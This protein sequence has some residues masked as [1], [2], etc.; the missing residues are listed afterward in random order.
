LG[1]FVKKVIPLKR[2][3]FP[4]FLFFLLLTIFLPNFGSLGRI[5]FNSKRIFIS[6]SAVK[7]KFSSF[8][9][10]KTCLVIFSISACFFLEK[11]LFSQLQKLKIFGLV[12]IKLFTVFKLKSKIRAKMVKNKEKEKGA[13]IPILS[14]KIPAKNEAGREKSPMTI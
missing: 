9:N 10:F 7:I 5:L 14:H 8:A 6:I 12:Q 3:Y 11:I 2:F 13:K 1:N 4:E